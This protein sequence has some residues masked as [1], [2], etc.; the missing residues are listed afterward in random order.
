MSN[1]SIQKTLIVAASLCVI[2]SVVVSSASVVLRP[3]QQYNQELD[4]KR[5]ILEAGGLYTEGADI[6]E[7]FKQIET[8]IIDLSTGEYTDAVDPESYDA[9]AAAASKDLGID[10]PKTSIS[11]ELSAERSTSRSTW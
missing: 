11:V 6:E 9:R 5:N 4:K 7:A 1:D 2:C 8:K 3:T 10:I